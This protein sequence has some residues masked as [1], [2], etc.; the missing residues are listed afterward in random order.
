MILIIARALKSNFLLRI[1]AGI[2][3]K[4]EIN[5]AMAAI[6]NKTTN[7]ISSKNKAKGVLKKKSIKART[8]PIKNENVNML[9]KS[10]LLTSFLLIIDED[11]PTFVKSCENPRKTVTNATSP[12]SSGVSN[13]ININPLKNTEAWFSN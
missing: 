6:W 1:A 4:G 10:N 11:K 8:S 3:P 2:A 13:L 5:K 9:S 7:L 12:K